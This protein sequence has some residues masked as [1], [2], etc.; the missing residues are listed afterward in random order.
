MIR[1]VTKQLMYVAAAMAGMAATV[2]RASAP[3]NMPTQNPSQNM[4]IR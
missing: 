1:A 2:G 4:C 3:L